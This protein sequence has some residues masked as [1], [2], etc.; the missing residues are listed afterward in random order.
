[1]AHNFEIPRTKTEYNTLKSHETFPTWKADPLLRFD[2]TGHLVL[3]SGVYRDW[4][5]SA[6]RRTLRDLLGLRDPEEAIENFATREY[7]VK[8][9]KD[10]DD[11]RNLVRNVAPTGGP[12]L[13][14]PDLTPDKEALDVG[15]DMLTKNGGMV[16]G[17]DHKDQPSKDLI[18]D[19]IKQGQVKHVFVEEF[20]IE[21]QADID[22]YLSSPSAEMSAELAKHIADKKSYY[23]VDFEPMLIAAREKGVKIHGIDSVE[24]DPGVDVG[25]PRYHERRVVMM[26]AVAKRVFDKVRQNHPEEPFAAMTGH[27]HVNTVEGGIPGLSQIMGVPGVNYD[28]QAGK[29]VHLPEDTSKRGM[30]SPL[31]QE[32]VDACLKKAAIDY[33]EAFQRFQKSKEYTSADPK[34]STT[35][36]LDKVQVTVIAQQLAQQ[37][38]TNGKL[39]TKGNIAGLLK[40]RAVSNAFG[41]IFQATFTRNQRQTDL[42]KALDEGNLDG[43]KSALDADPYL[44]QYEYDPTDETNLLHGATQKGHTALVEELLNRG[45]DPN[46][47]DHH[48]KS[49]LHM[50][51]SQEPSSDKRS[52]PA[53]LVKALLANG[54]NAK[55]KDPNGKSPLDLAQMGP[56]ANGEIMQ[57]FTMAGEANFVDLFI[58]R[59]I[60][61]TKRLYK[62]T[63]KPGMA[64]LDEAEVRKAAAD[65][66]EKLGGNDLDKTILTS[67][68]DVANAMSLPEVVKEIARLIEVTSTRNTE[69]NKVKDC[70]SNHDIAELEKLL[71]ADPILARTEIDE[72]MPLAL[73]A[74]Q[75]KSDIIDVF[76]KYGVSIDQVNSKGRTALLEVCSQEIG[77]TD[78]G[79]QKEATKNSLALITKGANVN[80]RN[81]AGQTPLHQAAFR[82]NT[83]LMGV[84]FDLGAD[85]KLKDKR[86]WTAHDTA[87]G[88]TNKEAEEFFYNENKG[89]RDPKLVDAFDPKAKVLTST[90][91]ILCQATMCNDPAQ[92]SEVR[93]NYETLYADPT[94]RPMLDLA[95]AA[96]CKGR[97]PPKGGLRIFVNNSNVVGPL[98]GQT[99]GPSGAYDEQTNSLLIPMKSDGKEKDP[100]GTLAHELTHFAAHMITDDEE[101]MPF[102]EDEEKTE[103]LTAI[104]ADIKKLHLLNNK[105]EADQFVLDRFSG[106]MDTYANRGGDKQLLQEYLVG[107]PQIASVY[108]MEYVEKMVPNL[109]KYYKKFTERCAKVLETDP[110]F[111]EGRVRISKEA[112]SGVVKRLD[113]TGAKPPKR[114]VREK[115][116]YEQF[117]KPDSGFLLGEG[118]SDAARVKSLLDKVKQDY[119]SKHGKRKDLKDRTIVYQPGDFELSQ[120]QQEA[121]EKKIAQVE[122]V[123]ISEI[124][125]GSLPAKVT[126]DGVRKLIEELSN[127]CHAKEG[128]EL[129]DSLRNRTGNWVKNEKINYVDFQISK[130]NKLSQAELAEAIVYRAQAEAHGDGERIGRDTTVNEKKQSELVKQLTETFGKQEHQSQLKDP[131]KLIATMSKALSIDTNKSVYLR[132]DD[133]DHVSIDKRKAKRVW[134]RQLKAIRP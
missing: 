9:A 11:A 91:D 102:K 123:L 118:D 131:A 89:E 56:C 6:E 84:L 47:T 5:T 80:A 28:K 124:A 107:I 15:G 22:K 66:A 125:K 111:A 37:F 114:N 110:R 93:K 75:G 19:L 13:P 24:A 14:P 77:K 129:N 108:G 90:I 51:L 112:N 25:D 29:L 126:A 101:T 115:L 60:E 33:K 10:R 85:P 2:D 95:A 31:E 92:E 127:T 59:F 61:D 55:L 63:W 106:R 97:K 79:K 103:Y 83:E 71:S 132:S 113:D 41:P 86:G 68:E 94:M 104:E 99:I 50:A 21:L 122:K 34:P 98:F 120:Q 130:G 58:S 76:L 72:K 38:V 73:A 27:M 57:E 82:N 116:E 20:P 49:A 32:F 48:G 26:N 44:L 7:K 40:D 43:L 67:P 121:L 65:M 35:D 69:R 100:I 70:I 74:L 3:F 4:G 23:N 39:T 16:L 30:S 54:A 88:S 36:K 53:S 105:S 18:R 42:K 62:P 52:L 117:I 81:G 87:L 17:Y 119:I 133:V 109:A 78:S 46:A 64:Q 128:N 45:M 8:M 96:A 1:M 12:P 134:L